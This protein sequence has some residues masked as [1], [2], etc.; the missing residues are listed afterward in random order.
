VIRGSKN[1]L[2]ASEVF[3]EAKQKLPTISF[4]TVYNSLRYLKAAGHISEVQFGGATR[5]D[6]MTHRHDH[7]LCT[8]CGAL[9]DIEMEVPQEIVTR[10]AEYSKFEPESL[11]FTLRGKC[12]ECADETPRRSIGSQRQYKAKQLSKFQKKTSHKAHREHR[13]K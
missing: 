2:T 1:H 4:A 5:F 9:V 13:D 8:E 3:A 10:A 6:A 7:A 11:E 12:P